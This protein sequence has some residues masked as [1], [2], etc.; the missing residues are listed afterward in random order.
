MCVRV[1]ACMQYVHLNNIIKY[2][3]STNNSSTEYSKIMYKIFI[4]ITLFY[5]I[6][7]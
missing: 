4:G 5:N 6:S 3:F 2:V 1:I 7:T